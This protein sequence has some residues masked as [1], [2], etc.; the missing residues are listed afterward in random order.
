MAD[1]TLREQAHAWLAIDPDPETRDELQQ[2]LDGDTD[3]LAR[4]FDGRLEFGTAGLR[5]LIGAGPRRMNR[6]VVMQ[7]TAGLARYLARTVEGA[8]ERGVVVAHDA[9]IGSVRFAL[10]AC[11]VLAAAGFRVIR[12]DDIT[13]TPVCSWAVSRYDAAGGIMVTASHNPPLY[14]GYKVYWGNGA[15]IIPPH[16][17]GIAAAIDEV[18][19]HH[20]PRLD[21]DELLEHPLVRTVGA[22]D[23]RAYLQAVLERADASAAPHRA[24]TRIAYSPMHGVGAHLAE[25]LLEQAGYRA[26]STVAEQRTPDGTF[27]TVAFPNPEEA[28]ALDLL[29]AHADEMG[30]DLALANDPDADRLAVAVRGPD[31]AWVTLT[32][33]QTGVLLGDAAMRRNG[34]PCLVGTTL[35]SS[36]MLPALADKRGAH[37]HVTLTGFKWIANIA[38]QREAET[39]LPFV[40]GYEEAIGFTIGDLVRDKDGISALL[41]VAD[42]AAT[43]A[44]QGQTLL[45][46]LDELYAEV[47]VHLSRQQSI[48][49]SPDDPRPTPGDRLRAAPPTHIAGR[50]IVSTDD[51]R[52][53]TRTFADGRTEPLELGRADVLIFV[54]NDGARV[55]VRPSGTEPKVKCY[56]EVIEDVAHGDVA[57][58]RTRA[59]E[60]LAEIVREHQ[61]ELAS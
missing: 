57:A 32:G 53:G 43:L 54:L 50:A 11:A 47:G 24:A 22:A 13:A 28:G 10:D 1:T 20:I 21:D 35:V 16:D 37:C 39:G 8:R 9:R 26:V 59:A 5:G 2:L 61:R 15:Q 14:N 12:Y 34:G 19:H 30:A 6:L 49:F 4:R 17:A 29:L 44:A 7:S 38:M 42:L 23:E 36:R 40:F 52:T 27:P 25:P 45:D 31:R 46:R 18:L 33:D 3:E 60:R 58:A 51:L 48:A 55:I 56:Y 41:A